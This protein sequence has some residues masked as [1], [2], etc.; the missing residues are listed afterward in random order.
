V[1][2]SHLK[3]AGVDNWGRS[4]EVLRALD[5]ARA[6]Q[7]VCADCYPYAAGSTTLDLKQVDERVE[8]TITGCTRFP[9]LAGRSLKQIAEGWDVS[10]MEA[11][12]RLQPAGAIYHSIAESDMRRILAHPATMVGSDGLPHDAH[13][14]P[15]LWGTFPRVLGKYCREEKLFSLAQ[16]VHKMT[17]MPA[18]RF[19][20]TGRGLIRA[21]YAADMVLFDAEA[22]IDTATFAE[23]ARAARGIAHVWVNGV[24]TYVTDGATKMRAGQFL[25]R[26]S[27]KA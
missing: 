27:S 3:C 26:G 25:A 14:H 4:G 17:G 19:G 18:E 20:L 1:V 13:P 5:A 21:G 10:Q 7:A 9:E 15:R 8:I 24:L 22:V 6:R 2:I 16:A 11:A 23:P 12:K